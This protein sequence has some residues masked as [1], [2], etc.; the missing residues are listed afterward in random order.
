MRFVEKGFHMSIGQHLSV[1]LRTV[2]SK[3]GMGSPYGKVFAIGFNKT[4]TTSLHEI[5]GQLGYLSYHGTK[6][7]NTSRPAIYYMYD[8]FCDGVPDDVPRLDQ[9]FPGSKFILQVRDLDAWLDSRLE[10]ILRLPKGKKRDPDWTAEVSSVE[11]WIKQRN[12]YHIEVLNYFKDRPEDLL[13]INFIRD[14][15]SADKIARFLGHEAAVEKSHANKNP[16]AGKTLKNKD[17]IVSAFSALNIPEDEHK[18]DIYCPSLPGDHSDDI[19]ADTGM[20][21]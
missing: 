14:P 6:W 4:G 3:L 20:A 2:R 8:S 18:Y 17:M 15:A 5:F 12:A 11:K 16:G 9:M 21:P 19:P 1:G 7:R 10:H 13:L